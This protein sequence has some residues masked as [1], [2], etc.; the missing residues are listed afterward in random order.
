MEKKLQ[1]ICE[2]VFLA[3]KMPKIISRAIAVEDTA[4][5][6]SKSDQALNLYYCLC[7]QM[8]VILDR[9]IEKLPLRQRDGARVID[10]SKHTHKI[11]PVFDEIVYINRIEKGIE[12][13]F[14]YKC[15]HCNLQQFY[16]HDRNSNVTFIFKGAVVSSSQKKSD[17]VIPLAS[18]MSN[19][20][21]EAKS[22]TTNLG[23]FSSV[24]VSTISDDED[25]L[26]EKEI[27]DSYALNAKIIE[28]QLERKGMNKRKAD[29]EDD[30]SQKRT[31]PRG[32][33]LERM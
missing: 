14:R 5:K 17:K 13:Q 7:G 20:Q 24:T 22:K 26:E 8:A 25:E 2:N 10:G 29:E 30:Q 4:K 11:T 15:K 6:G 27:A 9:V 1:K 32:T 19:P 23:K 33:L 21:R 12:K 16:R 31:K 18:T 28:K 3:F